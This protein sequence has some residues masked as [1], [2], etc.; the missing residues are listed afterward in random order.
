MQRNWSQRIR[1]MVFLAT[2]HRG[3]DY[4]AVLNLIL[5]ISGAAGI[6]SAREYVNDLTTGST[7]TQLINDDFGKFAHELLIHSFY[8]TLET[9]IGVSSTLIVD[10]N[11]A[12]LGAGFRNERVHYLNANHRDICKFHSTEDS[13]YISLKNTLG[14]AVH[15]V[16]HDKLFIRNRIELLPIEL[17]E[18][19]ESLTRRILAKSGASFLWSRLVM[20]ELEN[21]YGYETILEIIEGIPEVPELSHALQ[22]D[23][24]VHLPSAKSAIEG[25]CGNLLCVDKQGDDV[26]HVI[27]NS[28]REF[29]LTDDAGDFKIARSQAHERM[30]LVCLRLLVSPEM[31]PPKNR[32]LVNQKQPQRAPSLMLDYAITQFSEHVYFAPFE[33][34]DLL[35]ALSD[36]LTSTVLSWVE[37]LAARNDLHR[38]IR[39]AKNL[40]AYLDRRARYRSPR[41]YVKTI[42]SWATDLSRLVTKFGTLASSPQSI[43]FLIPP[44][45]PISS[46]IYQQ[47]GRVDDGLT[48][49]GNRSENWDDCIATIAFEN[50]TPAT[51]ASGNNL[52]AVGFESGKIHLFN[53]GSFQKELEIEHDLSIDLLYFDPSG[54]F[55]AACSRKFVTLWDL[56]GNILWSV[57]I[58]ARCLLLMSCSGYLLGVTGHGYVFKWQISTGDVLE[59]R[60]YEYQPPLSAGKVESAL[61]KAPFAASISPGLDVLALAYRNS[62]VCLF[63][64]ESA[65]FIGWAIDGNWRAPSQLVF[66]P[67]PDVGLLLVAYSESHLALF[68]SWSGGLVHCQEPEKPA[69]LNAVSCSA[70]GHTIATVD[71]L[72]NLR[73]WD[74]ESLSVLYHVLTP[75][76]SFRLLNFTSD[77]FN[78]ADIDDDKMRVWSP[79]AL[80]RKNVEEEASTSDQASIIPVTE[81]QYELFRTSKLTAMEAH[82]VLPLVFVGNQTGQVLAYNSNDGQCMGVAYSHDVSIRSI[83][84]TPARRGQEAIIKLLLDAGANVIDTTSVGIYQR[85]SLSA[86]AKRGHEAV[87]RL[88]LD[89]SADTIWTNTDGGMALEAAVGRRREALVKCLLKHKADFDLKYGGARIPLLGPGYD[90]DRRNAYGRTPLS[91]AAGK[92]HEAIVKML[93]ESKANVDSR[94]LTGRTPLSWAAKYGHETIIRLLIAT[95]NVD[96]DVK[97]ACGRTPLFLAIW[98]GHVPV[99][100]LLLEKGKADVTSNDVDGQALLTCSL[101]HRR[102]S[103]TELLF[104][105]GRFETNWKDRKGRS[106]LSQAAALGNKVAFK[107]LLDMGTIDINSKDNEGQTALCIAAVRSEEAIVKMLLDTGKVDINAKDNDGRTALFHIAH[108]S[109]YKVTRLLVNTGE[110]DMDLRDALGNEPVYLPAWKRYSTWHTR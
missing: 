18:D 50:E 3:S 97:D 28:T 40:K 48:L 56:E 25:L 61:N 70:D 73:I 15:D 68:D 93:L 52:L 96:I 35:I 30:A 62:P 95:G 88:L 77:G 109:H 32:R 91:V 67:N 43:Y 17:E 65:N 107:H 80:V 22:L 41:H 81:G 46:S 75:D 76:R 38:L 100:K 6:S 44:L 101:F 63:D 83:V 53:H 105:T 90:I 98:K 20:D 108:Y 84:L 4:A 89:A 8:E 23:I 27:H 16:L 110:A 94:D 72:G 71:I 47:F 58:G 1:C 49:L 42:E 74:F 102:S 29:L 82:K 54:A 34:D 85:S 69:I 92:G 13:N 51:L 57:R 11:S 55:I 24:K 31:Q 2:P 59:Q 45:C 14:S 78:L 5:R 33:S 104:D 64:F 7:S 79:S 36:F 86:A 12:V 66:N 106:M 21:V 10:K 39:T 26:A 103:I 9:K 37:K 60:S 99:V 87:V 19:K